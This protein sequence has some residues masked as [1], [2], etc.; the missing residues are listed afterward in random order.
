MD[1]ALV[2]TKD[3]WRTI[4][5]QN[6]LWITKWESPTE[7]IFFPSHPEYLYNQGESLS[8]I[9][10]LFHSMAYWTLL[11]NFSWSLP[12]SPGHFVS[13]YNY[14]VIRSSGN[15]LIRSRRMNSQTFWNRWSCM[16]SDPLL[17]W[18][19]KITETLSSSIKTF[20]HIDKILENV[21]SLAILA[22]EAD[23]LSSSKSSTNSLT[24]HW[25]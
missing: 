19:S 2:S 17:Y 22:S 21:N 11:R 15:N 8:L 1:S 9:S 7:S 12:L 5:N 3:I 25:Y 10:S 18:S 16:L 6:A 14:F 23:K 24:I 4:H 20:K 13:L